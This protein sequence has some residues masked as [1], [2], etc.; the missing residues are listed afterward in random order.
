MN[1]MKQIGIEKITLNIGYG[2]DT[3][4][5]EKAVKILGI[6]SNS[7]VVKTSTIKRVPTWQLRPG[8]EIGV[9]VVLRGK[10]AEELLSRLLKANN[11]LIN[12]KSFD[13]NG[14]FSFGIKEYID[15]PEVKYDTEVGI[16]GLE[17]AITLKRPGFRIKLRRLE[18]RKIPYK[19]RITKEESMDFIKNKFGVKISE[20]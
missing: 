4:L 19:H 8:L 13:N 2:N 17:V 11:N 7:K 10:K 9:M 14:N 3:S 16:I 20:E 15:I 18:K 12:P 1:P 6:I 5:S